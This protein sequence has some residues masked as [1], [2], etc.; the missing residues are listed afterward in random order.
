MCRSFGFLGALAMTNMNA[1]TARGPMASITIRNLDDAVKRKLSLRAAHQNRSMEDEA[2][3]AKRRPA[4]K[5]RAVAMWLILR[6][7]R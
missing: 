1:M 5:A 2:R 4:A 3:N 7:V 6:D